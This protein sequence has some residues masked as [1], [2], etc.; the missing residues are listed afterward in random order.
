MKIKVCF[1]KC[2][3]I[4]WPPQFARFQ[5]KG[6]YFEEKHPNPD[7]HIQNQWISLGAVHGYNVPKKKPNGTLLAQTWVF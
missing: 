6:F 2:P 1:P 5:L 7:C 3:P 4:T